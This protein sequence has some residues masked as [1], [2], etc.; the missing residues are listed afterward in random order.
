VIK[1]IGQLR[2]YFRAKRVELK[3]LFDDELWHEQPPLM[4]RKGIF[5]RLLR[6]GYLLYDGFREDQL[7]LHAASLTYNTL[8][9]LIPLLA[10][11][12]AV[13]EGLGYDQ[14]LEAYLTDYF[15]G[16]PPEMQAFI[17][18]IFAQ[19]ADADFTKIGGIGAAV[20]L[21][22]VVQVLNRIEVTFNQIWGLRRS[23]GIMRNASNY[24]AIIVVV[25]ILLVTA[26]TLNASLGVS[27]LVLGGLGLN[28]LLPFLVTWAAF[29]FLYFAMP[30]TRVR[31]WAAVSSGFA[32]ALIWNLW[33]KAYIAFQPGMNRYNVI[34]GTLAIF[35]IFL[36]WLYV[37]WTIILIGAR[38]TF[39]I[40][41]S[42]SFRPEQ[43]GSN[44]S[45]RAQYRVAVTVLAQCARAL[46]GD[47]SRFRAA[48][49]EQVNRVPRPLLSRVLNMLTDR[50]LIAEVA[51]ESE[52]YLLTC[53]PEQVVLTDVFDMVLDEGETR[54]D[55]HLTVDPYPIPEPGSSKTLADL[56]ETPRD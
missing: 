52:V 47:G 12:L 32:G 11:S 1:H 9:A 31:V 4:T 43:H 27:D 16:Y 54:E 49:F 33:L 30:N 23:R 3:R 18:K 40:Q 5:Y 21:V 44:A 2:E 15:V 26:I 24:I 29:A 56:L 37:N 38:L 14:M 53:E 35:P 28:W 42:G 8:I 25:P 10:M 39:V 17:D 45:P 22:V 36:I 46:R 19:I 41:K 50:D 48:E 51:D 34:Y 7:R 6:F 13:L 55:L 20:L